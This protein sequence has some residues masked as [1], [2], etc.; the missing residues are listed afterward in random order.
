MWKGKCWNF[1]KTEPNFISFHSFTQ[2]EGSSRFLQ[3]GKGKV[4]FDFSKKS[5]ERV[6]SLRVLSDDY[7]SLIPVQDG[8]TYDVV[9]TKF[10]A[11]G[12]DGFDVLRNFKAEELK[13]DEFDVAKAYIAQRSPVY[14]GIEGRVLLLNV[15]QAPVTGAA[16]TV[17][18][19]L[20]TLV[21]VVS[22]QF[23]RS[24]S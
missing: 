24:F 10:L 22:L 13:K 3:I 8:D 7:Q 20:M 2:N 17:K 5:G 14:P 23:F 19:S 12:N 21:A 1:R 18:L 4:V 11:D 15:D 16:G 6:D 9:M